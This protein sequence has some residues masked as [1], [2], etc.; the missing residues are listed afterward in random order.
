MKDLLWLDDIRDP[1]NEQWNNY[2]AVHIG[3]PSNMQ[4][5]WVKNFNEFKLHIEVNGVPDYICFDHDLSIFDIVVD[6][7]GNKKY[8]EMTSEFTGYDAA[9]YLVNYCIDNK[10]QLP[11]WHVHSAN[12]VGK[13]NIIK[14]LKNYENS[15]I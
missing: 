14:Y 15:K 12:P 9:K 11:K 4:I 10:L 5:F 1:T 3:N 8:R 6:E 2:I 13:E 7:K